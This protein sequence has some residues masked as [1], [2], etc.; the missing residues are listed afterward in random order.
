MEL[1][2]SSISADTEHFPNFEDC[3]KCSECSD[4]N[5]PL[6]QYAYELC[7]IGTF[8]YS[9]F[10]VSL[11]PYRFII[12]RRR[13]GSFHKNLNLDFPHFIGKYAGY[14][15]ADIFCE[16]YDLV[17]DGSMTY[18]LYFHNTMLKIYGNTNITKGISCVYHF[19]MHT[20]NWNTHV[21]DIYSRELIYNYPGCD[22]NYQFNYDIIINCSYLV[23]KNNYTTIKVQISKSMPIISQI[24]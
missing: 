4:P 23:S 21:W 18:M 1:D 15:L 9:V 11:R 24:I 22:F 6:L 13:D 7:N 12:A 19:S 14:T 5:C 8:T 2:M 16:W 20:C 3:K 17:Y 10:I